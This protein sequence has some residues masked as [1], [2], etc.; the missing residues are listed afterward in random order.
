[1]IGSSAHFQDYDLWFLAR[2]SAFVDSGDAYH[3]ARAIDEGL[4]YPGRRLFHFSDRLTFLTGLKK[5]SMSLGRD[6]ESRAFDAS[7]RD[8]QDLLA[9]DI[10]PGPSF[11]MAVE[12]C[13][14]GDRADEQF[15]LGNFDGA[16]I[17]YEQI[18]QRL[19]SE[20]RYDAY[21][22]TRAAVRMGHGLLLSGRFEDALD[23]VN[24]VL[25][26]HFFE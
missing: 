7:I 1:M 9:D 18:F 5:A 16:L 11:A 10:F 23:F 15:K 14:L 21:L 17:L 20:Q 13:A 25:T 3:Q 8:L 22:L 24:A 4:A 12:L 26:Q 19:E 6:D 2:H